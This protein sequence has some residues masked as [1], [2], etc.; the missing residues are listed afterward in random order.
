LT[1][2]EYL[3][4]SKRLK[5]SVLIPTAYR[6]PEQPIRVTVDQLKGTLSGRMRRSALKPGAVLF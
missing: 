2:T 3:A 5:D 6:A 4:L 1:P